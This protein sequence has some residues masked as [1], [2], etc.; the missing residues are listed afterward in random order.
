MMMG[1]G[2]LFM[3]AVLAIPILLVVGVAVWM[4]RQTAQQNQPHPPAVNPQVVIPSQRVVSPAPS[5]SAARAC[6]HCGAGLQT[7]WTHCPQCGAPTA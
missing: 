6:S 3:L 4:M 2:L 1:F 7:D 5:S